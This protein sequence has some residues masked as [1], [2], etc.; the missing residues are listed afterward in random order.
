MLK[1]RLY[2]P[3][4]QTEREIII[5]DFSLVIFASVGLSGNIMWGCK[6]LSTKGHHIKYEINK[7]L[8]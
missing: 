1:Q 8:S 2:K 7:G 4:T 6:L 3:N 5:G